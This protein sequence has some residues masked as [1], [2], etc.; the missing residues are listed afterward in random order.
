MNLTNEAPNGAV[1]GLA[2]QPLS[3]ANTEILD[4]P[5]NGSR[6]PWL[7]ALGA[8]PFGVVGSDPTQ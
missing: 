7:R 3:A 5:D 1:R 2:Q 6:H 4:D 8:Y